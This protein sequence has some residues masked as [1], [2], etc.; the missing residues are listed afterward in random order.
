[1]VCVL[2][3]I[4][5]AGH[6]RGWAS[7]VPV[8]RGRAG[9]LSGEALSRA[10]RGAVVKLPVTTTCEKLTRGLAILATHAP[11]AR[12]QTTAEAVHVWFRTDRKTLPA[13]DYDDLVRLGW[14]ETGAGWHVD[15][16]AR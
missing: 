9:H 12:V 3:P 15:T 1:M 2:S 10:P 11:R 4:H 16:V 8:V 13:A 6:A 14:R 5:V 7:D